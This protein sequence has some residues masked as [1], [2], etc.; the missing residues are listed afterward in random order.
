MAASFAV[1]TSVTASIAFTDAGGNAAVVDG[2]PVWECNPPEAATLIP[3]ADGL[4]CV[5]VFGG[6][7]GTL[8]IKAT[9]D[10]DMTGGVHDLVVTGEVELHAGEAVSATMTFSDAPVA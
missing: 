1:G 10:S 5:I 9:A 2:A 8:Q 3:A 6:T 4:S 7:I